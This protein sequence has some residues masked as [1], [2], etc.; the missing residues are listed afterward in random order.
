MISHPS[1]YD[2]SSLTQ[3]ASWGFPPVAIQRYNQK[4][5]R[6]LFPWQIECLLID[7]AA[8]LRGKSLIYTAPTSGGKTLVSEILMLRR[9]GLRHP[10]EERPLEVS[11]S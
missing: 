6:T 1:S 5:I 3:L 9:I 8:P 2:P 7:N 4:G 10:Q 11:L